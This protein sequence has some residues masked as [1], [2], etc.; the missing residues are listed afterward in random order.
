FAPRSPNRDTDRPTIS[1][2]C[3]ALHT[4]HSQQIKTRYL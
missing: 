4:R 2:A 3:R 1:R